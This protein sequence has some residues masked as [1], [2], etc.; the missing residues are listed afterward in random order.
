MKLACVFPGQGSQ[1]RGMGEDL[2]DQYPEL[3]AQADELLGYSLREL[4]LQDAQRVLGLT[5]YTQPALYV[6]GA[7]RYVDWLAQGNP[8]PDYVAGHS[9]GEYCALFAAKAFDFVA[10]LKHVKKRGELMSC[11][12]KGA[13]AAVLNIDRSQIENILGGLPYRNIDIANINSRKQCILSGLYDE[14]FAENLTKAF[15]VAGA[16]FIPLNVSAAFH[17]P[18]MKDVEAQFGEYLSRFEFSEL[19]LRVVSNYTARP[20][21]A[22]NYVDLLRLQISHPVRWYESISWLMAQGCEDFKEL[23]AG[24]V[25]TKLYAKISQDPFTIPLEACL[26]NGQNTRV[27]NKPSRKL[28][29]MYAGQGSQYFQ[30]GRGLFDS[31][32]PFKKAMIRCD[33]EAYAVS[34]ISLISTLYQCADKGEP[35]TDIQH[36]NAALYAIGYALTETMIA[37]GFTPDGVLGHSLGEYVA[38]AVAGAIDWRDGLA[39]VIR[40]AALLKPYSGRGGMLSVL[41]SPDLF[42]R[43]GQT[44][45]C[46]TLAGVNYD[47]NFLVSGESAALDLAQSR[48]DAEGHVAV[49]LP[50][51][52]AFHAGQI[53]GV[54]DDFLATAKIE[55]CNPALPVFSAMQGRQLGATWLE[56]PAQYFWDVIR[57]RIRFDELMKKAFVDDTQYYFVDLSASGSLANFLKHGYA[58]R[59]RCKS[60]IN[61]FGNNL[62]SLGALTSELAALR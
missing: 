12:P 32:P 13:M 42:T 53:D 11:A 1:H 59:H 54:K 7:L 46:L 48:L 5:Q 37:Q 35:F 21:P 56:D 62:V 15:S 58:G 34:G 41:A 30:M 14:L 16:A 52:I 40:Q 43:S 61:Q 36:T 26:R 44:F 6:V 9:L 47:K 25:L 55:V 31:C 51:R 45:R 3:V 60:A 20:Y 27:G 33:S 39:L 22:T 28:I 4:C 19:K 18:Y 8:V 23:G 38:A 17:S 10:G 57:G 24:N 29:F 49:R 50:V 2:F